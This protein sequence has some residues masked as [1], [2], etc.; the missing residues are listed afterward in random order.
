MI[1]TDF[2][3]VFVF[4]AL[5]YDN[6]ILMVIAITHVKSLRKL[7]QNNLVRILF[8]CNSYFPSYLNLTVHLH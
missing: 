5:L 7:L 4:D 1:Y 6:V 8:C 2:V 3:S